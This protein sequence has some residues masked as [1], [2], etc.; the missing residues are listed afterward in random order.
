MTHSLHSDKAKA[1]SADDSWLILPV[2]PDKAP[3]VD[4]S[5]LI[6]PINPDKAPKVKGKSHYI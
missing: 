4:D 3:N 5:Q 2:N 6:L 1:Q